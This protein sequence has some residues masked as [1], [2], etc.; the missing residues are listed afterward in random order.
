MATSPAPAL[1]AA[2]AANASR[3]S[4]SAHQR[5]QKAGQ[6]VVTEPARPSCSERRRPVIETQVLSDS[7]I[8][9][10]PSGSLDWMAAVSLRDAI[11]DSL[12]PGV[13]VVMDLRRLEFIDAVGIGAMVGSVSRV[14]AVDGHAERCGASGEVRHRLELA[15]VYRPVRRCSETNGHDAA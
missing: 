5:Q 10:Q 15:G 11:G 9:C 4:V 2:A 13:D 12:R 3:A 7:S 6:P 1:A 8:V 14:P